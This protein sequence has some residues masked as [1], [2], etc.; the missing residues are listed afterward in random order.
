[1]TME[2]YKYMNCPIDAKIGSTQ[3]GDEGAETSDG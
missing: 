3:K 1:M 2:G